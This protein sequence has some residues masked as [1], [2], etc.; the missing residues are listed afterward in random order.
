MLP[1]NGARAMNA[2]GRA[3]TVAVTR[4]IVS[5]TH[6]GMMMDS[7]ETRTDYEQAIAILNG[8]SML[9]P[10]IAHL[11]ALDRE[12]QALRESLAEVRRQRQAWEYTQKGL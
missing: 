1:L 4:R 3:W 9:L 10:T 2:P 5:T 8:T 7:D 11:R 6:G 12:A